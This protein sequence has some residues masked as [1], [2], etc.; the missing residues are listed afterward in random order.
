MNSDLK[1]IYLNTLIDNFI[2]HYNLLM[3]ELNKIN[4]YVDINEERINIIDDN[5]STIKKL[6]LIKNKIEFHK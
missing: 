5:I 2:N 4:K 3:I 1:I 6:D